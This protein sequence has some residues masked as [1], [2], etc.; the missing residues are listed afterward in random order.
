MAEVFDFLMVE[1][2]ADRINLD[3]LFQLGTNE[4]ID[5]GS[6]TSRNLSVPE[7][8]A[9]KI[10]R[11]VV[12]LVADLPRRSTPEVVW[13]L[14]E[15]ELLVH[16]NRI[17][18]SLSS[19]LVIITNSFQCAEVDGMTHIPVPLGVGTKKA[20]AGLVMSSFTDLEG[21]NV[22]TDIWTDAITAF[23]WECL[24]E[25]CRT[26]TA[27]VGKDSQGRALIPGAI[28][29]TTGQLLIQPMARHRLSKVL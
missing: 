18:L 1:E 6:K 29:A 24:V 28:A 21:P 27:G 5:S 16:T 17:K 20:P 11:G 13:T 19:G 14:G 9:Q 22:I 2:L 12:R 23:A 3:W 10:L 26:I 15:N 4:V 7:G 25:L 8:E